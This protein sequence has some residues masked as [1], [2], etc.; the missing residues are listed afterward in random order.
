MICNLRKVLKIC[1]TIESPFVDMTGH[2]TDLEDCSNF[3]AN[4][5]LWR[6]VRIDVSKDR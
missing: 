4:Q 2:K 1:V 5:P 3:F 6:M